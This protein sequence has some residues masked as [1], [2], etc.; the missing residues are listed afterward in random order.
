MIASPRQ[1]K[2]FFFLIQRNNN[3]LDKLIA[4]RSLFRTNLNSIWL[5]N[6]YIISFQFIMIY[7]IRSLHSNDMYEKK[8]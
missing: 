3:K 5:G 2:L 4:S 8:S 7:S 6:N 1:Q